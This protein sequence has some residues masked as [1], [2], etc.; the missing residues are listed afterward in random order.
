[1]KIC[2]MSLRYKWSVSLFS[3]KQ[4]IKYRTKLKSSLSN[5][6]QQFYLLLSDWLIKKY[7]YDIKQ[8]Y[9]AGIKQE[10]FLALAWVS[11]K[12]CP[13]HSFLADWWCNNTKQKQNIIDI[14]IKITWL[15]TGLLF[16]GSANLLLSDGL[17]SLTPRP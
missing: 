6:A 9:Q 12:P 11:V 1:M 10:S 5:W 8:K 15:Q 7:G 13:S 2:L 3:V 14:I 16:N 4:L 17:L